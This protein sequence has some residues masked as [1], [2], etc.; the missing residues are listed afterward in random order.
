MKIFVFNIFEKGQILRR[1]SGLALSKLK[2]FAYEVLGIKIGKKGCV[3]FISEEIFEK[4]SKMKILVLKF[5]TPSTKYFFC[6]NK[7]IYLQ[8]LIEII[9]KYH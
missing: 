6:F 3:E 2:I 9:F 1:F 4:Y 8:P 5:G 7:K